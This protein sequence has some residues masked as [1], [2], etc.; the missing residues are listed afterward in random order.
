[1]SDV[2]L[3]RQ[4]WQLV[5]PVHAVLYYAP[6]V[7]AEAA[8]LGYAT[9]TRW[10]SYF[11]WRGAPMGAARDHAISAAFYSFNPAMVRQYIPVAWHVAT[12]EKVLEARVRAIDV[13]MRALLADAI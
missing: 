1:M 5:E 13:A 2:S 8:S 3:A 6:E 7:F 11:A 10:P 12:P 9:D 4:M